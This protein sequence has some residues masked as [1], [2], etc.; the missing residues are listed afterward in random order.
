MKLN[1]LQIRELQDNLNAWRTKEAII[2]AIVEDTVLE[3]EDRLKDIV[4]E[5]LK[6]YE[7]FKDKDDVEL[8]ELAEAIVEQHI[9]W[10][11]QVEYID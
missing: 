6:E 9:G 7:D 3:I 5:W 8:T 4:F 10:I 2:D 11:P 1:T